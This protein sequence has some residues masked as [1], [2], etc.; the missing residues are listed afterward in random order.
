[1]SADDVR[2]FARRWPGFGSIRPVW[3][4]FSDNGDLVDCSD[5]D[6]IDDGAF[7]AMSQDAQTWGVYWTN[8]QGTG[9]KTVTVDTHHVF[10]TC[11]TDCAMF[12]YRGARIRPDIF[13]PHGLDIQLALEALHMTD[14]FTYWKDKKTGRVSLIA[15]TNYGMP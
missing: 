4:Q 12:L 11:G 10:G 15:G 13:N 1:M 3:F 9:R 8:A 6:G 5:N 14:R 7:V 2:Q